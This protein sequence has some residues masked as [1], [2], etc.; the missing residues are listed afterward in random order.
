[1]DQGQ[2]PSIGKASKKK[3]IIKNLDKYFLQIQVCSPLDRREVSG[4]A[5]IE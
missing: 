4:I 1:M 2:L 5:A 3:E